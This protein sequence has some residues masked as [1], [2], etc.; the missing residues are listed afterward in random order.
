MVAEMVEGLG[1]TFWEQKMVSARSPQAENP[2]TVS[3]N[4]ER[5]LELEFGR[6][7]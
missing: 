7:L 5:L 3:C 6:P 1:V 2:L 4:Y